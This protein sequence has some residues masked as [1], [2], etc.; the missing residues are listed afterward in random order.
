M[1]TTRWN[2]SISTETDQTLRRFLASQGGGRKG[3]LSRFVE[4]AVR[5]HILELSA[6]DAKAA[7]ACVREA[8]LDAMVS[9]ALDW[10]KSQ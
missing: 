3:Y 7:N 10:A 2:L 5:A 4:E 9:E 1:A 6:K 8:D